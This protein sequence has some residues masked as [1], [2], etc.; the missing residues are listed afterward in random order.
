MRFRGHINGRRSP[1]HTPKMLPV[2][3]SPGLSMENMC[4]IK[5]MTSV[6]QFANKRLNELTVTITSAMSIICLYYKWR[7]LQLSICT[8]KPSEIYK[9]DWDRWLVLIDRVNREKWYSCHYYCWNI[10]ALLLKFSQYI[11]SH[12]PVTPTSFFH[13]SANDK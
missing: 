3:C 12:F 4:P 7:F 5:T 8:I 13:I 11:W 9:C 2:A 10:A 6:I 1:M